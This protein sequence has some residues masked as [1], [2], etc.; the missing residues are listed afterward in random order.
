M[1]CIVSDVYARYQAGLLSENLF[2]VQGLFW[3][4]N[5]ICQKVRPKILDGIAHLL[6]DCFDDFTPSEFRLL[7]SLARHLD[8]LVFGLAYDDNP[9]KRDLYALPRKTIDSIRERFGEAAVAAGSP[10]DVREPRSFTEFAV[11]SIFWRTWSA[12]PADLRPNITIQPCQTVPHEIET[13]GREVKH[14][15]HD[16]QVPADAIVVVM[17]CLGD[18]AADIRSIFAQLGVP[19]RVLHQPSVADSAAVGYVFALLEAAQTWQRDG[20][21][22]VLTSPWYAPENPPEQ[23]LQSLFVRLASL[24]QIISGEDEWKSRLERLATRLAGKLGEDI[25]AFLHKFPLAVP[26]TDAL[27]CQVEHLGQLWAAWPSSAGL[28]DHARFLGD[29]IEAVGVAR[30]LERLTGAERDAESRA[31]REFQVC[32]GRFLQVPDSGV[33]VSRTEFVKQFHQACRR[34]TYAWPDPGCGVLCVSPDEIRHLEFDYVFLCG[35][36]EGD[37]PSRPVRSAIY[38]D[39]DYT[40]FIKHARVPLE[41]SDVHNDRSLLLFHHILGAARKRLWISWHGLDGGGRTRLPSPFLADLEELFPDAQLSRPLPRDDAFVPVADRIASLRDLRNAA[42]CN[43]PEWRMAFDAELE[44]LSRTGA[45]E[46]ARDSFDA[47]DAYDGVLMADDVYNWLWNRFAVDHVF[48]ANQLETYRSC[49]FRFFVDRVLGLEEADVPVAEFDARIRGSIMHEVLEALHAAFR[50]RHL[51]EVDESEAL[52]VTVAHLNHLFDT[53]AWR[54]QT[55]PPGVVDVER[56]NLAK[57]LERYIRIERARVKEIDWKPSHFEV[58]FGQAGET[59]H[60][61]SDK[62]DPFP[63]QTPIGP[64]PLAG[65]IDRID[66]HA[67]NERLARI[68]DYKSSLNVSANDFESGRSLQL[69]LYAMALDEY[70]LP[71]RQCVEA[72]FVEVGRE[73]RCEA[74]NSTRAPRTDLAWRERASVARGVVAECVGGILRGQFP[75][76]PETTKACKYCSA[77]G[78]C[79]HTEARAA[80]KK[81]AYVRLSFVRP[82]DQDAAAT[83]ADIVH[84]AFAAA[85]KALGMDPVNNPTFAGYETSEQILDLMSKDMTVILATHG[86]QPVGS[87]RFTI[88]REDPSLGYL[89]RLVVLPDFQRHGIGRR[90]CEAVAICLRYHGVRRIRLAYAIPMDHL[91]GFYGSLGYRPLESFA[92]DG[93]GVQAQWMEKTLGDG[94]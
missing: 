32:L 34:T 30:G 27:R 2:D 46:K 91:R 55:A 47:P 3:R 89:K 1:D 76:L 62:T 22:D 50:G 40:W 57:R 90:L 9:S 93:V 24:A 66:L 23:G 60:N 11:E 10:C 83:I 44:P 72:W 92:I 63:L 5:E 54:S 79:R 36:N 26:A 94:C 29:L 12:C 42:V 4:A 20:V 17:P 59:R 64:V 25:K 48:S 58:A 52:D 14:L 15:L 61:E 31:Y 28:R 53:R 16:G 49:P 73:K 43:G 39:D 8:R 45:I 82:G 41:D 33:K 78:V 7:E 74:V 80:R 38:G 67:D 75:A 19:V 87:I 70:L 71:E 56:E 21:L 84:E 88:D 13:V 68:I 37:L 65:R 18:V 51:A 69:A 77:V 86:D 85:E 81:A 35:A 6:L